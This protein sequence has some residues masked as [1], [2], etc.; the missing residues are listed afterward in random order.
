[1]T[2]VE[3]FSQRPRVPK[4]ELPDPVSAVLALVDRLTPQEKERVLRELADMLR[5]VP[6]PMAGDVLGVV[7]QLIPRDRHWTVSELKQRID[8]HGVE[9]TPKEIYNAIGYLTRKGG[10]K[11]VGYGRYV[12]AGVEIATSDDVGGESARHE[13]FYASTRDHRMGEE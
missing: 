12:V 3:P 7:V 1:M 4:E 10:L 2:K 9:A 8:E 5:A 6:A 13:D 11:R